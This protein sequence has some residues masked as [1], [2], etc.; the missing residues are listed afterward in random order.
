MLKTINKN[1]IYFIDYVIRTNA[2][3]PRL[4]TITQP[5]D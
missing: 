3:P 5:T 1:F 4:K 2:F